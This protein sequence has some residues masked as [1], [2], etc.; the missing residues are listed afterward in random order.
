MIGIQACRRA[1]PLA[2]VVLLAGC[3][4]QP[5]GTADGDATTPSPPP[6]SASAGTPS[7]APSPS[8]A[9][10]CP[11]EGVRLEQGGGDAAAGLRVLSITLVNCGTETYR[12]K[13]YPAVQALDEDRAPLDVRVLNGVTEILGTMPWDGPPQPVTLRPGRRAG[14]ALAWRST[15]DDISKPPANGKY[16]RI[17]PLAGRPAQTLEP[18]GP[19]D[20]GST[21]RFAVSAWQPSAD[22]TEAPAKR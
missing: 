4:P 17:A 12:L 6:P 8:T 7:G 22:P 19:L 13:G 21:G 11:P 16:L 18:D 5:I 10:T 2:A 1:V 3:A 20:F 14:F 15:Y 9:P